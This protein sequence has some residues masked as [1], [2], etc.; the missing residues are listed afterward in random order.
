MADHALAE[1][2]HICSLGL[3]LGA[4]ASE[5]AAS[6]QEYLPSRHVV[7]TLPDRHGRPAR[8][9]FPT[10]TLTSDDKLGVFADTN[11][12]MALERTL[13]ASFGGL[14]HGG[15]L[16]RNSAEYGG[17]L[18]NTPMYDRIL[19]PLG[20][21]RWLRTAVRR[22]ERGLGLLFLSRPAGEPNYS[23]REEARV[24]ALQ[25]FLAHILEV[26]DGTYVEDLRTGDDRGL[27]V[28]D[29]RGR[30]MHL[31]PIAQVL[32]RMI[33]FPQGVGGADLSSLWDAALAGLT[34]RLYAIRGGCP[35]PL[36]PFWRHQNAWGRFELRAQPLLPAASDTLLAAIHIRR[37]RPAVVR[38]TRALATLGLPPRQ[39]EIA[40]LLA[41]GAQNAAI[42]TRLGLRPSTVAG[43]VK[44]I[45]RRV[46]IDSRTA[47]RELLLGSSIVQRQAP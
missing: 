21:E 28:A 25:P 24:A 40:L 41:Q 32:R 14:M 6:L 45:Y 2:R 22:G 46:G 12:Y 37:F 9:L 5:I 27:V 33:V 4:V 29:T 13:D 10:C 39:Q 8:F 35:T 15:R 7:F 36:P 16:M 23:A 44:D 31:C 47:M 34:A 3:P 17:R 42:A 26:P 19:R 1:I 38:M 30:V 20:L 43:T 18:V 11:R